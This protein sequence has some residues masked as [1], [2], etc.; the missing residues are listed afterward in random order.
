MRDG[1]WLA[2]RS[3]GAGARARVP[4]MHARVSPAPVCVRCVRKC[5][6]HW[7]IARG[8]HCGYL[9]SSLSSQAL[10]CDGAAVC[11]EIDTRQLGITAGMPPLTA[12]T[13]RQGSG[14][15]AA[16]S[17]RAESSA[18]ASDD[19][20]RIASSNKG[21]SARTGSRVLEGGAGSFLQS[22]RRGG[23][24]RTGKKRS[25]QGEDHEDSPGDVG[26]R[27]HDGRLREPALD[28]GAVAARGARS[29]EITQDGLV[30]RWAPRTGGQANPSG[31]SG[32]SSD[33]DAGVRFMPLAAVATPT[34]TPA[35]RAVSV[36]E[37]ARKER[38]DRARTI[39]ACTT[40]LEFVNKVV[41][42]HLGRWRINRGRTCHW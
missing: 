36:Q 8:S 18:V 7:G 15:K 31:I 26:A 23:D 32:D 16:K 29:G 42:P 25:R 11:P 41:W 1:A 22:A 14:G 24:A 12:N 35:R 5:S 40:A 37:A 19:E 4:G 10:P 13:R 39:A 9:E 17:N 21:A 2:V 3:V 33:E 38:E 28:V 6:R 27:T 34:A 20:S 30:T